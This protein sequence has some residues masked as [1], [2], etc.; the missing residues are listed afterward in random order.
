MLLLPDFFPTP[1]LDGARTEFG[2]VI[3]GIDVIRD[4][5]GDET[6]DSIEILRRGAPLPAPMVL[7]ADRVLVPLHELSTAP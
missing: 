2:R 7:N 5:R 6:V 3:S 4:M 1:H